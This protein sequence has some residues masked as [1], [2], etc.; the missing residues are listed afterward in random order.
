MHFENPIKR[1][2]SRKIMVGDVAVGGDAPISIQTM[3]NTETTDVA[4]TV[5]QIQQAQDAG[6]DI[7]RVSV[8]SMD[9][10]EA[11]GRIR[12][13]VNIP[14]VADIHFDYRIALRVAELGVDCLRINPG[15]IGR[16]D[17]VRAVVDAARDHN[18][19][20]RI[21]VNAGSLEKDLQKKYGE[22]TPE[23]LV[24][25]AM[26]HIDILDRL[27]FQEYKL[28]L[29]ASDIFMTVAAYRQIASQIEQPLHLGITEAGG[30]RGGTV[31][32]SIGL[33]LLL[34]DGIGDTIRVSLAAD[35][36]QEVKVGWD[37][38]KSLKVRSRG[39]NFIACPSCSRQNFD[40]IKT[41]NDLETRVEDIRTNMDVAVIGCVVNGPGEAK[42]VDLGLAGGQ[43]NLVYI[44]G[45][46]AGKLNNETLVDD[47][48]RLIRERADQLDKERDNLIVSG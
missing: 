16:E 10:A 13:Q 19:P 33:G 2:K 18:I 30:L 31:K 37:M 15:N 3:T 42:E 41:M 23:A 32:S 35:P 1:R 7:V 5:A 46:P 28:S 6:A 27:D 17:R 14:L 43:P 44:D 36:V 39:I 20:I 34:W 47:L 12:K 26:R 25:S 45:K 48:E 40:V 21:G 4:A 22:P 9:A 11:F 8:P 24:E 29:K 38:L